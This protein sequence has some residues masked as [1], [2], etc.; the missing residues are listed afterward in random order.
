M[1]SPQSMPGNSGL[2]Q[3]DES[4]VGSPGASAREE[5]RPEYAETNVSS[6]TSPGPADTQ[7][8]SSGEPAVTQIGGA[9]RTN[10]GPFS[11]GEGA[12]VGQQFGD[13][14]VER[15][16]GKGGMG[17]V[18]LAT[19]VSLDR[20]VAL[21]T[22]SSELA[23]REDFVKRFVRE[24]RAMGRLH[25][26]NIVQVYATDTR[27]GTHF[28]AIEF[29]DG[30]SL[31][32]WMNTL[33]KLP[34]GDAVHV[35]I[36]CCEALRHALG[37]RMI[38]RDIKP[39]NVLVTANGVVKV[40]DFGLAKA[41]DDDQSM[42]QTGAGMGTP[43]YMA[44]EQARSAKH[45]DH[46]SD[47][48]A[49]GVMLYYLCTGELPFTGSSLVEII[50]AKERGSY[51]PPRRI[52]PA[53]PEK[54]D[55]IIGKMIA[56]DPSQRYGDYGELSGDLT[57]LGIHHDS[58][59]FVESDEK[60]LLGQASFTTASH[61]SG[62]VINAG[63]S[64]VLKSV[65]DAR[66]RE[67]RTHAEADKVWLVRHVNKVGKPATT[68]MTTRQ[69]QDGIRNGFLDLAAK[70]K[71]S[72]K[73]EFLPLAH[74]R[75]FEELATKRAAAAEANAKKSQMEGLYAQAIRGERWRKLARWVKGLFGSVTSL[76]LFLLY[77][78]VAAGAIYALYLYGPVAF[79]Y[80]A[81][82]FGLK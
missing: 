44:P 53:I 29:I 72:K 25:H 62:K 16:L 2:P 71:K 26:P 11:G 20:K 69:I 43:L 77:L 37:K 27:N 9:D 4:A 21:K 64:R 45:V 7:P 66:E 79:D 80:L 8:S 75:E 38:H 57:A 61:L 58:L 52:E 82:Q 32:D 18:Y 33:G 22:L 19:Q 50:E 81:G 74:Y 6:A 70:A 12:S 67:R 36:V 48:F 39:D 76:V 34:V 78:A 46:R 35:L 51:T 42:T 60:A 28:V 17:E 31:Q 1:A 73:G 15:Q 3:L 63:P 59:S 65:E 13:F 23:S 54:L 56:R 47:V 14:L 10:A 5:A 55:L 41:L 24:Y 40:A 49:L 30:R 68:K